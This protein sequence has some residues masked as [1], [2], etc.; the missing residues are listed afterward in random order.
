METNSAGKL[1]VQG[2]RN[3]IT[4]KVASIT[5]NILYHSQS[6]KLHL[7]LHSHDP[8]CSLR[9]CSANLLSVLL[10]ALHLL[11]TA[12]LSH[13]H[14]LKSGILFPIHS[15]PVTLDSFCCQFL[16]PQNC[17]VLNC[18]TQC[19]QSAAHLYEQF[20]QVQH[21]RFVTLGPLCHAQRWLPRV[22]LL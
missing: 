4:S 6:S 14:P 2:Q 11:P 19:S 22:V 5:F 12:L 8:I 20:L 9:S 18:M 21:I 1:W 10:F 13:S 15:L 17:C 7:F 16:P 3:K